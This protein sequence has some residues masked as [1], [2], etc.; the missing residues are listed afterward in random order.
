[1]GDRLHFKTEQA[2]KRLSEGQTLTI[3]GTSFGPLNSEEI[4]L[5]SIL[6]KNRDTLIEERGIELAKHVMELFGEKGV[7]G[8]QEPRSPAPITMPGAWRLFSIQ[9]SCFRGLAPANVNWS[10][11]FTDGK[12]F[13]L[14]GPNGCGKSSVL[15]AIIWCFTGYILRD[16][17]APSA[18]QDVPVYSA[19]GRPS[20]AGSRPDALTLIDES[21]QN[22]TAEKEYWVEVEILAGDKDA[23]Q[24][25]W[26]RRHS[27]DG[28]FKSSDKTNWAP[29][30]SIEEAGISELD[31]ELHLLMP[32]RVTHLCFGKDTDLVRLFSQIVGLDDLEDIAN[33]AAS[34]HTALV[35][36][37]NKIERAVESED[38]T[39]AKIISS[40]KDSGLQSLRSLRAF[41]AAM[42]P[43]RTSEN[44]KEF[45]LELKN[46]V[47]QRKRELARDL[48]IRLPEEDSNDYASFKEHLD[49]LPGQVQVAIDELGKPVS[50]IFPTSIGLDGLSDI[51]LVET[52]AKLEK[53]EEGARQ[54]VQERL[55]WARQEAD[56]EKLS[57][58]LVAAEHYR[59]GSSSCPVC[60]QDLSPVPHVRRQLEELHLKAN[61]QHLKKTFDD[62]E[63]ALIKDLDEIVSR[64][65]QSEGIQTLSQRILSDWETLK[66][67]RFPGLL[68][69]IAATFDGAIAELSQ[70]PGSEPVKE[71]TSFLGN[72]KDQFPEAF[73][74]LHNSLGAAYRYMQL[75]R[76]LVRWRD[77]LTKALVRVLQQSHGQGPDC[78][79]TI[80]TRGRKFSNELNQLKDALKQ[81]RDLFASQKNCEN[82]VRQVE[83]YRRV[84]AATDKCKALGQL[85]RQEVCGAVKQ[86]EPSLKKN[87]ECLCKEHLFPLDLLTAGNAANPSVKNEIN[88]YFKIGTERVPI[89]PFSNA[90]RLRALALS[91]IFAL[92]NKSSGSL[93][94]LICDDPALSLDDEHMARFVDNLVKPLLD[95]MQVILR[96]TL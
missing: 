56:D 83:N 11:E 38:E 79:A 1:M 72:Y 62:L 50:A 2:I 65:R 41:D 73:A 87:Y 82:L 64:T 93:G 74:R 90:G 17:C 24:R 63:L 95:R 57:L 19:G 59:E 29:I 68:R 70:L 96:F 22:T 15:G 3:G 8:R 85:V 36:E 67:A 88:A 12:S 61:R 52:T 42:A 48:G 13:L 9:A 80:I 18:P 66:S 51:E 86:V 40:L 44:I 84:A 76:S 39:L 26:L 14:F 37:A 27:V 60:T 35:R 46:L 10:H 78:V 77:Q 94:I 28:L 55:A 6:A 33:L 16:D 89:G 31:A 71:P 92:L 25:Q 91:F 53:F 30:R 21:E 20:S 49:N 47:E 32:A 23:Q 4:R 43:A 45:G 58:M 34:A 5:L 69:G 7:L 75:A 54:K 81:T